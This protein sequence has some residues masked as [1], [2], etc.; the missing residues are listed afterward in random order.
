MYGGAINTTATPVAQYLELQRATITP[1]L[2]QESKALTYEEVTGILK[3]LI[4]TPD[5][6]RSFFDFA[7]KNKFPLT[8]IAEVSQAWFSFEEKYNTIDVEARAAA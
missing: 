5:Q 1:V 4:K 2:A 7:T 8:T 6:M 3:P